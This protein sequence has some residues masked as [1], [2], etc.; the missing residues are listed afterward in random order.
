MMLAEIMGKEIKCRPESC[1][2]TNAINANLQF[3]DP[4]SILL[5]SKKPVITRTLD[6]YQDAVFINNEIKITC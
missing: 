2:G 1:R 6:M 5:D 4:F 3:Y